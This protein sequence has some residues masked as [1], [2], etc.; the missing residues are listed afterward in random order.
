MPAK[1]SRRMTFTINNPTE[2][3]RSRIKDA[4]AV[5]IKAGMET[6][7][8]GT[9]H[10]QG[11]VI[12]KK[13]VTFKHLMKTFGQKCH[14]EKMKGTWDDQDYC[15]KGEQSHE[16]WE[17]YGRDGPNF[18]R[19]ADIIRN[20][21]GPS[22]QGA[23]ADITAFRDAI[24][25]GATNDALNDEFPGMCIRYPRYIDFTR[26]ANAEAAVERLP[27]GGKEM[28]VWIWSRTAS[29]G[30]TSW[31]QDNIDPDY[32]GILY[33]KSPDR[34]WD[35]YNN[36][37]VIVYNDPPDYWNKT[38]WANIKVQCDEKPFRAQGAVG[39]GK[40]LIRYTNIVVTCNMPPN[41][42]FAGCGYNPSVFEAR[43]PEVYEITDKMWEK[44][45]AE[46]SDVG[47]K[48][49]VSPFIV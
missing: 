41:E 34:W 40:R 22:G 15:L 37:P 19:N 32:T 27:R 5:C 31:V 10:V 3:C 44:L 33:E 26:S 43:F 12:W 45:P 7:L 48:L 6:G 35:G 1:Q 39:G 21:A 13:P 20:D 14:A 28:G 46:M 30:K 4:D 36:E 29:L 38:F 8:A 11:A 47:S 2:G 49:N 9:Q 23:R 18:G 24:R 42:Y 25:A 17:Q 16:E